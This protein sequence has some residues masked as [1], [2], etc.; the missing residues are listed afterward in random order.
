MWIKVEDKL[1]EESDMYLLV[2]CEG[3]NVQSTFYSEN[4]EFMKLFGNSYSRKV[5]GKLSGF[6]Q[7]SHEYG[8]KITHWQPLPKHPEKL[9]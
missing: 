4:R 6:F 1:P 9:K 2:A 3:G 5:H 7:L 8:Y